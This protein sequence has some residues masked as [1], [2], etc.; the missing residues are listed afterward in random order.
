MGATPPQRLLAPTRAG[1]RHAVG[2]ADQPARPSRPLVAHH[3]RSWPSRTRQTGCCWCARHTTLP[4]WADLH[5]PHRSGHTA[6]REAQPA[7]QGG[8][9]VYVS[10]HLNNLRASFMLSMVGVLRCTELW[11]TADFMFHAKSSLASCSQETQSQGPKL[12]EAT[13]QPQPTSDHPL[14]MHTSSIRNMP[15]M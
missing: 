9:D 4:G 13:C 5:R 7:A 14:P 3:L 8:N 6:H 1:R 12:S 15:L 11:G 10:L 2:P